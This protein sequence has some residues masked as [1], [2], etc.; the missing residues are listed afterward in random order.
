MEK[1]RITFR[2]CR[3]DCRWNVLHLPEEKDQ[4]GTREE[5]VF[6]VN[7]E[8]EL[9]QSI[10]KLAMTAV[11]GLAN[12]GVN[13]FILRLDG[14]LQ[15][16]SICMGSDEDQ[17]C[18]IARKIPAEDVVC[19]GDIADYHVQL[20]V[21][22]FGIMQ[23]IEPLRFAVL[24]ADHLYHDDIGRINAEFTESDCA[25]LPMYWFSPDFYIMVMPG[26]DG[27]EETVDFWVGRRYA[28]R[29]CLLAEISDAGLPLKD[30]IIDW[31][32]YFRF[33]LNLSF[34]ISELLDA[35]EDIASD[36]NGSI[37]IVGREDGEG[38]LP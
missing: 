34:C 15:F 24:T 31:E 4:P 30:Y 36:G 16:V 35:D 28:D 1:E 21:S 23:E 27:D 5:I 8:D 20:G 10:E 22:S 17:I 19:A 29:R 11:Q 2:D 38:L 18:R 33:I 6:A 32:D 12:D 14:S 3:M 25:G 9:D 26:V 37:M 13:I 7:D